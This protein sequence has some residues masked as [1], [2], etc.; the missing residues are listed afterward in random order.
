MIDH[1]DVKDWSGEM[2]ADVGVD[3]SSSPRISVE[4]MQGVWGAGKPRTSLVA[5]CGHSPYW[6]VGNVLQ[7]RTGHYRRSET[8]TGISF[9][10]QG[11]VI[12][13]TWG[14]M[15]EIIILGIVN[16]DENVACGG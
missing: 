15:H 16:R 3:Q 8:P 6:L 2:Y 11:S 7:A 14:E 13:R 9:R 5:I 4:P 12:K 1:C 10:S